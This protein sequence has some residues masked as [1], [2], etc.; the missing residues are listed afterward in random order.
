M[1]MN[2][3]TEKSILSAKKIHMVGVGGVGMS[4]LARLFVDKKIEVTGSDL[5]DSELISKLRAEHNIEVH[6]GSKEEILTNDHDYLVYLSL[7]HI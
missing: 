4:G 1:F 2:T 5:H 6:I 7:I 3:A